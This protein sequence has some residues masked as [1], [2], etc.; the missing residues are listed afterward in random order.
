MEQEKPK[1][2]KN[3]LTLEKAIDLVKDGIDIAERIL[4]GKR[5]LIAGATGLVIGF[6]AGVMLGPV[7]EKDCAPHVAEAIKRQSDD[8]LKNWIKG[9]KTSGW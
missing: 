9:P 3:W 8:G 2:E 1:K 5:A 6:G 7:S 4:G